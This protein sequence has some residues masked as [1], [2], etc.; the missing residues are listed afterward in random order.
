MATLPSDLSLDL[1][2]G[3]V[4]S[5]GEHQS[6]YTSIQAAVNAVIDILAGGSS[7]QHFVS[8]GGATVSWGSGGISVIDD[9]T[10]SGSV[11][12]A[13][14]TQTRLG[15]NLP[16]SYKD[17]I[18]EVMGKADAPAD[19]LVQF[20]GD[21]SG[22]YYWQDMEGHA[23]TVAPTEG[24]AATSGK[25][26][27]SFGGSPGLGNIAELRI[28]SY[29]TPAVGK[30]QYRSDYGFATNNSTGTIKVGQATG[31]LNSA[32]AVTRIHLFLNGANF[33]VGTRFVLYGRG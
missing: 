1:V 33:A 5:A 11:L 31:F 22:N 27:T 21:S 23:T 26:G 7:G 3:P 18:L 29:N 28:P 14:D 10:V 4:I 6:N 17:V 8:G 32:S 9:Y 24:I 16:T 30:I 13:Y 20:N 15:G 12:A 2:I 25:V 19:L